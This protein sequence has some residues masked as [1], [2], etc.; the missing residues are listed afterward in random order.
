LNRYQTSLLA[1]SFPL[2]RI[3]TMTVA[4]FKTFLALA[5]I[6]GALGNSD[7]KSKSIELQRCTSIGVGPKAMADGST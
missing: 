4:A 6:L 7:R 3:Y 2:Y 5:T 1:T